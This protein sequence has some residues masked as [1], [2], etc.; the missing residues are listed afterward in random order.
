M[1]G[2]H[3]HKLTGLSE[4]LVRKPRLSN[5]KRMPVR[6]IKL[7]INVNHVKLLVHPKLVNVLPNENG[8]MLGRIRISADVLGDHLPYP[9][10][11]SQP[12]PA[13]ACDRMPAYL[14]NAKVSIHP[15]LAGRYHVWFRAEPEGMLECELSFDQPVFALFHGL[16]QFALPRKNQDAASVR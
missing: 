15:G 8:P 4:R 14:D 9:R 7:L 12:F 16:G 6:P 13:H 3:G 1:A 2:Q 10:F 11:I 5:L